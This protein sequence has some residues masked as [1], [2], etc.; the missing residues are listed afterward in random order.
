MKLSIDI[1]KKLQHKKYRLEYGYFIAEGEHLVQELL[2]AAALNPELLEAQLYFTASYTGAKGALNSHEISEAQMVK[3]SETKTPQGVLAVVPIKALLEKTQASE[4]ERVYYLH[5]VQDPGNL[6]T[7]IRT[8]AWFGASRCILSPGSVD[9]FNSKVVRASMGAIFHVPFETEVSLSEL[10]S[11]FPRLA[12]LDMNGTPVADSSFANFDA[13][14][15]GNEA[16][17]LPEG[18]QASAYTIPGSRRIE[19]L[20]LASAVNICAYELTR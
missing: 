5:E 9:P 19:S 20:N 14:V 6:G 17:G 12:C 3:L 7:I 18:L 8:L 1:L 15:F 4:I 16:R 11:R 10:H 2:A 13:Y